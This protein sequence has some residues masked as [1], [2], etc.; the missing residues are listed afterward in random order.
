VVTVLDQERDRAAERPP[1]PDPAPDRRAIGLDLH[2]PAAPVAELAAREVTVDP[3][4]VDRQPRREALDDGDEARP[5]GFSG[6]GEAQS[7][8]ENFKATCQG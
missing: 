2:A 5:V 4:A 1:V 7:G 8:H 3:V 6:C